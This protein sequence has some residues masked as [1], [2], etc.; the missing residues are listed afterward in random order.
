MRG[1]ISGSQL[2]DEI[3]NKNIMMGMTHESISRGSRGEI[4]SEHN[5]FP[6]NMNVKDPTNRLSN[7]KSHQIAFVKKMAS[8]S[9][10]STEVDFV[11]T[12]PH[13][14]FGYNMNKHNFNGESRYLAD[15]GTPDLY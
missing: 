11:T 1:S 3:N 12:E 9:R 4:S 14:N 8:E 2:K 15:S 5:A 10:P 7:K 13:S 6:G